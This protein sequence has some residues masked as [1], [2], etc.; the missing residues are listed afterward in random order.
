MSKKWYNYIV[1]VDD[2]AGAEPDSPNVSPNSTRNAPASAKSAAQ[3]VA[4]IAAGMAAEPQFTRPV[5]EPTSF[6]EI[7][8]A[9][10]IPEAPHGYSILGWRR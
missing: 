9:A 6:E 1:S 2:A 4:D 10:E 3:S 5:S 8:R 7:Y